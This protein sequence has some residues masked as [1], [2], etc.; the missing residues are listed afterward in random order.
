MPNLR[1]IEKRINS[2]RSTK[3]ITRTMEMVATAKIKKATDRVVA[4]APYAFSMVELLDYVAQYSQ[5]A[6]TPLL[7]HRDEVKR[8]LIVVIVSDR[9]LAGGFNSNVLRQAERVM[10][11]MQQRGIEVEI[12]ACGK[13]A[14]SY[15]NY[16]NIKPVLEFR[17][18]S[19][20]PTFE[21]AQALAAYI[22][23]GY[24]EGSLDE[25]I[26][27]Y[28]HTKNA[29]EQ[30]L[31]QERLLPMDSDFDTRFKIDTSFASEKPISAKASEASAI[32]AQTGI[33]QVL[34]AAEEVEGRSVVQDSI[35]FEPN[36]ASV[37]DKIL[38]AYIRVTLYHALIDS[39]A[40]E[41]GAR[42]T[43][44]KAA[45]DNASDMIDSLSRVYNRVRQGAITTEITEIVGGAA[46]LED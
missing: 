27:I 37:L 26:M 5:D 3:Q 18:L 45:T 20:D 46:A 43:A 24:T 15:L 35:M 29:A 39:A 32:A 16:R 40:A 22:I 38:P 12:A 36:E 21:E 4:A 7:R 19:A 9:G 30:M 25:I 8:A 41:Q 17:D 23:S 14:I 11:K 42:R 28:N 10:K 1:D 2:V 31:R 33:D 34:A 13:K 44:M 6:E